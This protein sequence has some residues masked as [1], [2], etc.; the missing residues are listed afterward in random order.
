M[1]TDWGYDD[2]DNTANKQGHH[3]MQGNDKSALD[4]NPGE[5]QVSESHDVSGMNPVPVGRNN[6]LPPIQLGQGSGE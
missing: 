1:P 5:N 3:Y 4:Y 2:K 6:K